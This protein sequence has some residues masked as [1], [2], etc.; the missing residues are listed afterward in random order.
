MTRNNRVFRS[1]GITQLASILSSSS[2]AKSMGVAHEDSDSLYE[3]AGD[4]EDIEHGVVDKVPEKTVVRP[5]GGIRG[6][7]RVSAG[8]TQQES[9]ERVMTR[10]RKRDQTSEGGT[11]GTSTNVE[12]DAAP[13]QADEHE[14]GDI[15]EGEPNAM[16]NQ[17]SRGRSMGKGL[18]RMSRGLNSKV[19]VV[20]V[21]GMRRPE[22]PMQAAKLASEGGIVLRQHMPIHLRWKDYKEDKSVLNDFVGKV[23]VKFSMDPNQKAVQIAC[24]DLLRG[25]QRQMRHRLKKTYFH[26]V[27]ANQVRTT[28]PL[29]GMTDDQWKA[30][31]EMW[32]SPKHK[33]Q[34]DKYKDAPPTAI[35]L[36]NELHCSSKTGLSEPVKEDIEQMKAIIAEPTEDGQ[37]PKTATEAV[38]E[39]L[40]KSKFLRNVGLE[41][42]APKKSATTVVHARV[43]ELKAEVQAERQGSA[44]L[45]C[46]IE[47]QQNQL[48][49]LT[50]K[51]EGTE[52]A[53]QKQQGELET[54]KKQA[55]ETNSL[56]R[57]LLSLNKD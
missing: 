45:R 27:P 6:S 50:S 3:P 21:E 13:A 30:L 10:K 43:Q 38:L 54:L 11:S 14:E 40:P 24:S 7:K 34:K 22:A 46:Q 8:P 5:T 26:D 44:A 20:I 23:S 28:S 47:Y 16:I 41:A 32:S 9:G 56:L 39:I 55:E 35:D 49:A 2:N 52:A 17:R 51:F 25:G 33:K 53:N 31:V 37:D 36:F 57:R 1:L 4:E 12:D 29:K 18:E 15:H 42:P 19:P 48:E